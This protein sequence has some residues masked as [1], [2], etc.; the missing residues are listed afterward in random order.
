MMRK[1]SCV[2]WLNKAMQGGTWIDI[3][4]YKNNGILVG[5]KWE[6]SVMRFDGID[7]YANCGSHESFDFTEEISIETLLYIH[8]KSM[9]DS[10]YI[11]GR[12]GCWD[13]YML[14]G[15][16]LGTK[17]FDSTGMPHHAYLL[18]TGSLF[19]QWIHLVATYDGSIVQMWRNGKAEGATDTA[20]FTIN[21]VPASDTLVGVDHTLSYYVHAGIALVRVFNIALSAK[22]IQENYQQC[23]RKI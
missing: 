4:K 16:Y 2:L 18:E 10:S 15:H 13:T 12:Q 20:S 23:Y 21:T 22:Q 19:N 5:G 14:M 11:V 8:S 7:D 17:I 6:H 3:S 1:D 9:E